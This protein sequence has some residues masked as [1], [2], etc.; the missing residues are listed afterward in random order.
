MSASYLEAVATRAESVLVAVAHVGDLDGAVG[1]G[2]ERGAVEQSLELRERG[3]HGEVVERR[4]LVGKVDGL[5]GA[6]L[7]D[8]LRI[9]Q[10]LLD[11][12]DA[13]VDV[14]GLELEGGSLRETL[15]FVDPYLSR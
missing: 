4:A 3:R 1:E 15:S 8:G 10:D 7:V 5:R 14:G 9:A 6:G 2:W 13:D 12:L 11:L